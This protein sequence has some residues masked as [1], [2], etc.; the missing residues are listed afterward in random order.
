MSAD[1]DNK[2]H[3]P[4]AK[5]LAELR[6][7]GTI[8]RSKD[9]TSGLVFLTTIILLFYMLSD[10][11]HCFEENFIS[12]F[13]SFKDLIA[14]PD[15]FGKFIKALAVKNFRMIFPVFLFAVLI[16][17][18]SP[19]IFGGWNFT[20]NVLKFDILKFNPIEGLKKYFSIKNAMV[21]LGK[22]FLKSTFILG[23]MVLFIF[24]KKDSI[25]SLSSYTLSS[26]ISNGF[27][28]IE[29]FI[30]IISFT[31]LLLIAIDMI[32]HYVSYQKNVKMSS[33]EVK[34]ES[35]SSEGNPEVKGRIKSKARALVKQLLA[36]TVP[37]A[38]VVI[39]NPTHY[40]VALRYDPD[41]DHAPKVIA[42]GKDFIAQQIRLIAI[43][44]GVPL[45]EAPSLARAIYYTAN[46]DHEVN[47]G[48]YMAVAIVLSYVH[49]LKNYQ[50][51]SGKAPNYVRE[52]ELPEEFI[53]DE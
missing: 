19:F 43:A 38:N 4:T 6:G 28:I 9:L 25:F 16:S 8:L 44:N 27:S 50:M 21:N 18:F 14:N 5:R 48:L 40:A 13:T 1:D 23:V 42:K 24:F 22:S 45:Y 17:L 39:T 34:E 30:V 26:A 32:H 41:K 33:Q 46:I 37:K 3:E 29:Q 10:V 31:L 11:K 51:G 36:K 49:Q 12:C 53:F 2:T 35:R 7:K 20:L 15:L 47:S 52:F